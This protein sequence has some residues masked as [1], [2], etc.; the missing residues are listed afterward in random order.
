M[1]MRMTP[2]VVA[3]AA[4]LTTAWVAGCGAT[5]APSATSTEAASADAD[6]GQFVVTYED[7]DTPDAVA[8][9]QFMQDHRVLEDLAADGTDL[10]KLPKDIPLHGKQCGEANAFWEP[11]TQSMIICYEDASGALDIFT[12]AGDPDPVKSAENIELA[13]FFHE[14]G[15]MAIDVYD[16]PVT[17]REE[18]VADQLAA[19][20]LLQPDDDGRLDP[21]NVQAVVDAAREYDA[22]SQMDGAEIDETAFADSHSM[23]LT[24]KYNLLCWLYGADPDGQAD[25]VSSGQ[26]PKDRADGCDDEWRKLDRAWY[27]LL[28]PHLKD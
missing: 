5:T 25:L 10:L 24:R 1:A 14:M 12:K 19:F 20:L 28:E 27:T 8:G 2:N 9:K 22:W 15:H 23:N 11:E 6:T 26:L 16:L 4:I 21:D 13:T 7:A 17:G 3:A 18:D